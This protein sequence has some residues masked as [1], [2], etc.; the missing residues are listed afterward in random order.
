MS[1]A[2]L[3]AEEVLPLLRDPRYTLPAG[4]FWVLTSDGILIKRIPPAERDQYV[5]LGRV[6]I[7]DPADLTKELPRRRLRILKADQDKSEAWLRPYQAH[8]KGPEP[9][10]VSFTVQ[11]MPFKLIPVLLQNRFGSATY[12]T[13]FNAQSI[14]GALFLT[15]PSEIARFGVTWTFAGWQDLPEGHPQKYAVSR[16]VIL[17]KLDKLFKLEYKK[18]EVRVSLKLGSDPEGATVLLDNTEYRT[19]VQVTNMIPRMVVLRAVERF[20]PEGKVKFYVFK[21]WT[22]QVGQK[23]ALTSD[24]RQIVINLMEDGA[25]LAEYQEEKEPEY[26]RAHKARIYYSKNDVRTKYTPRPFGMIGAWFNAVDGGN[27]EIYKRGR[28][29]FKESDLRNVIQEVE[30]KWFLSYSPKQTTTEDVDE[31][32]TIDSDEVQHPLAEMNWYFI[33]W[34]DQG[35]VVEIKAAYAG[36]AIISGASI[37][38][39][40]D[41][42]RMPR[43]FDPKDFV[44]GGLTTL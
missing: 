36:Y 21:K 13:D 3:P 18:V 35:G 42:T 12:Y 27:F 28:Y 30:D 38:L 8:P 41:R 29:K 26:F 5:E 25:A 34:Y 24:S 40:L 32:R 14:P 9:R 16:R 20:K 2:D 22:W 7:Y 6:R 37:R 4:L 17:A 31:E 15:V 10:M 39:V 44:E 19:N 33:V 23:Q 1:I 43:N 11:S